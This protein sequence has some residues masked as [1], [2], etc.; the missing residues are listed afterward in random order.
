MV[1]IPVGEIVRGTLVA[2]NIEQL[3]LLVVKL[4][5]GLKLPAPQAFTARTRQKWAVLVAK[6]VL[7]MKVV[8][9]SPDAL[10][11]IFPKMASVAI[12]IS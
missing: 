4:K 9:V 2:L 8:V 1:L 10:L 5:M 3:I 12:C 11:T 7:G 6:A